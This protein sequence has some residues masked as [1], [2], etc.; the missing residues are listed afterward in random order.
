MDFDKFKEGQFIQKPP[1]FESNNFLKWKNKFDSCVRS[2]DQDLWYIIS[3]GDFKPTK[4]KFENHND[5]LKGKLDKNLK[6]KIII[7]KTLPRVVWEVV[8]KNSRRE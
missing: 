2:I 1:V 8:F 4:T 6:A 3:I 7:Y 5:H